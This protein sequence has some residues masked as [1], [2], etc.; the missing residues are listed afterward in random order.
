MREIIFRGKRVDSGEWIEG[1]DIMNKTV[2]G[3]L[4]LANIGKDWVAVVPSTAGQFTG[5]TDRNGARIFEGDIVTGR[6]Q[7]KKITGCV[8][9]G[10]DASFYIYRKGL[11][12][13]GLN[14][15]DIWL[16]VIGNIYDNP[17]LLKG[18]DENG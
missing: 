7:D 8:K 13:V 16:A 14:N 17:E 2:R 12:N 18:G 11:F 3:E 10:D 5:V 15:A 9:Y 1:I 6:F 4:C